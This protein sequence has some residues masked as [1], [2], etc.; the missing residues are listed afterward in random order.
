MSK[1]N[2]ASEIEAKRQCVLQIADTLKRWST[3]NPD[4]RE[5]FTIASIT[6]A[7]GWSADMYVDLGF[8][9]EQELAKT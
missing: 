5:K 8:E 3:L 7:I 1:E 9:H 2:E 6:Q 4:A